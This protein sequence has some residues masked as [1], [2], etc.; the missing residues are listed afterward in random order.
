MKNGFKNLPQNSLH[1]KNVWNYTQQIPKS[2]VKLVKVIENNGEHM[3]A[4]NG[5]HMDVYNEERINEYNVITL[6]FLKK[7]NEKKIT[8][9]LS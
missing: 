5:E 9:F 3:N 8:K 2:L 6:K 1:I 4:Y 7:N